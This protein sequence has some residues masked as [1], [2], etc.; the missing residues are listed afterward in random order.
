MEIQEQT[1]SDEEDGSTGETDDAERDSDGGDQDNNRLYGN[2]GFQG[3][4]TETEDNDVILDASSS[5]CRRRARDY[6]YTSS[7][8]FLQLI[9]LFL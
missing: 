3:P 5:G 1:D 8:H 4:L 9:L 2:N 6:Y 7:G